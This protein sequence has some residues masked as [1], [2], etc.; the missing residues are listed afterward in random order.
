MNLNGKGN[1]KNKKV[2]IGDDAKRDKKA[3]KKEIAVITKHVIAALNQSDHTNKEEDDSETDK[4]DIVVLAVIDLKK[5]AKAE[6]KA[7]K[8][9]TSSNNLKSIFMRG[10]KQS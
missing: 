2:K 8:P 4:K 1:N 3:Q 5:Q 9:A 10:G 6:T 7:A